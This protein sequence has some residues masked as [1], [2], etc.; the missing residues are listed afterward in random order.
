MRREPPLQLRRTKHNW[1]T[2][3]ILGTMNKLKIMNQKKKKDTCN[4]T[5]ASK[6]YATRKKLNPN[7]PLKFHNGTSLASSAFHSDVHM[8]L[9]MPQHT[10]LHTE[11][12]C[13]PLQVTKPTA[14]YTTLFNQAKPPV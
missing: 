12:T 3:L 13:C 11:D 9:A 14:A 8:S 10:E 7:M 6:S 1:N 4:I 5:V 2:I